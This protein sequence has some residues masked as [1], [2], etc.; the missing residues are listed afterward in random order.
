MSETT[1][2]GAA[3]VTAVTPSAMPTKESVLAEVKATIEAAIAKAEAALGHELTAMRADLA[4]IEQ[5]PETFFA[6]IEAWFHK[7]L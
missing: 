1:V 7:H 2:T 5:V 6:R 4:A 3:G